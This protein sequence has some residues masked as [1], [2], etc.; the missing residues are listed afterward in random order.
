[1]CSNIIVSDYIV[2]VLARGLYCNSSEDICSAHVTVEPQLCQKRITTHV[3]SESSARTVWLP[4][5]QKID[6]VNTQQ[7]LLPSIKHYKKSI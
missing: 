5:C 6:E 4:N 7:T 3:D 1:M 2:K